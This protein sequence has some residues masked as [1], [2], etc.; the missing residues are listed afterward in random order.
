VKIQRQVITQSIFP[1]TH[2]LCLF[3]ENAAE[4]KEAQRLLDMPRARTTIG[5][6]LIPDLMRMVVVLTGQSSPASDEL[7]HMISGIFMTGNDQERITILDLRDRHELSPTA[8]FDPLRLLI[9]NDLQIIQTERVA[10]GVAFSA[11]HFNTLW[12]RMIEIPREGANPVTLD[13]LSVAR[14]NHPVDPKMVDCQREFLDRS[15]NNIADGEIQG[16]IASSLL[17]DAYPPDMHG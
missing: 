4:M 14:E 7:D 17:M 10:Q 6:Q 15:R 16:F 3:V 9:L 2:I 13:C 12:S 8:A 1:W 11:C 5:G